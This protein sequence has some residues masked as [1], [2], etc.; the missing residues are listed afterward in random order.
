MVIA[1]EELRLLGDKA[2]LKLPK[3]AFFCSREYP[4]RI[5]H[6]TNLW[7]LDQRANGHCVVSG[8]HSLMEQSIFRYLLQGPEQPIVYVLARGIQPN[9]RSE[10]GPEIKAGRLLFVTPF[11][12]DVTTT[13]QDTADI[14]NLLIAELADHFFI[15]YMAP[16]G[17]LDRL[18]QSKPAQGKPICTL[19]IPENK[20][21]LDRGAEI[22]RPGGIF[23]RHDFSLAWP[24]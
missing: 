5:E 15:P 4:A 3:T 14:R 17:N 11:E 12:P 24:V 1:P 22:Y 18:L 20:L 21:L 6:D 23:G 19:N 9:V 13:S 16:G 7:A 8:F 10:Y 2:L